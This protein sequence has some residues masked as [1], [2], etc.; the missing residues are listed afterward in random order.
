MW[1]L[2]TLALY[3]CTNSI[4]L[5]FIVNIVHIIT[6][7]LFSV[8][9]ATDVSMECIFVGIWNLLLHSTQTTTTAMNHA[10][11]FHKSPNSFIFCTFQLAVW[12]IKDMFCL[13]SSHAGKYY[14]NS[15]FMGDHFRGMKLLWISLCLQK[16]DCEQF[17]FSRSSFHIGM[18]SPCLLRKISGIQFWTA[19]SYKCITPPL[20]YV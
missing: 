15:Y 2:S 16:Y 3:A 17:I 7:Y 10:S 13:W 5:N 18:E 14:D 6:V 9:V 20:C 11:S 19:C 8:V 12:N 1:W 4:A